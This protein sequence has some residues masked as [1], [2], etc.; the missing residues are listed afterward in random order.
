[1]NE[2]TGNGS[3][4]ERDAGLVRALGVREIAFNTV[5]LVV[6]ASIF[7]LPA[8]PKLA[9]PSGIVAYVV[10]AITI[11]IVALCFAEAGSR[12]SATGGVYA[13]AE[14]AF[15]PFVGYLT[16]VVTWFGSFM[17]GGAAVAVALVNSIGVLIPAAA[18]TIVHNALLVLIYVALAAINIR[19]VQTGARFVEG[20]TIVKL[21]PL[22]LLI[23]VG[24]FYID[25]GNLT[26]TPTP[27]AHQIADGS[28]LL[29]FAFLGMECAVTPGG[30]IREPARTVPRSILLALLLITALYIAIQVVLQ[31]VLGPA[32]QQNPDAPLAAAAAKTMGGAGRLM[33]LAAAIVSAFGYLAGDM[34][35]SPRLLYAFGRDGHLPGV[36]ARVHE[37]FRTPHVAIV[38]HTSAALA[39]ALSST[40]GKLVIMATVSTLLIYGICA[41]SVIAMRMQ[42]IRTS[43][44]PFVVPGGP[45]VP[46]LACVVVAGLLSRATRVEY[47]AVAL[48]LGVAITLYGIVWLVRSRGQRAPAQ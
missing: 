21:T 41:V 18:N 9:W 42:G 25:P 10:C 35:T 1:M 13:Y 12:V 43:A 3:P 22:F 14:T 7:V 15:G 32:L 20:L 44:E 38:V 47:I 11:G 6:G 34:L 45:L 4:R 24:A 27:T 2:P 28:L 23:G 5:N 37:R 40:F 33:L 39:F 48:M 16:G 8:D 29:I 30:E 36:F 46:L 19:G 17:I 26:W 31:G